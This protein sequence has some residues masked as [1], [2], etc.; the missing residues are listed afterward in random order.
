ME[1]YSV[2]DARRRFSQIINSGE[3]VEVKHPNHP[4]IIIPKEK[5]QALEDEILMLEMDEAL[6]KAEGQ[7]RYSSE[8]VDAMMKAIQNHGSES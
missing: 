7:K 5:Y 6:K 3:T 1:I 4:V 8:E 2:T